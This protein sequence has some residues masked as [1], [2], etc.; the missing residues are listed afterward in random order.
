MTGLA[1]LGLVNS[2]PMMH[3]SGPMMQDEFGNVAFHAL[4]QS[5]N[6]TLDNV[7]VGSKYVIEV[8]AIPPSPLLDNGA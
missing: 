7:G 6:A 3:T 2:A 8:V 1:L 4:P 5:A